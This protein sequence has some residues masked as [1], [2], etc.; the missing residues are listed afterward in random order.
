MGM[1]LLPEKAKA[2][3]FLVSGVIELS[4]IFLTVLIDF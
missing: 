4:K 1:E 3:Y 2:P